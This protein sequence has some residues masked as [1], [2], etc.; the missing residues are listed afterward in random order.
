MKTT[1]KIKSFT[2]KSTIVQ[3]YW[4]DLLIFTYTVY[5][6]YRGGNIELFLREN[7]VTRQPDFDNL[8][9]FH[10]RTFILESY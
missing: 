3:E 8:S 1:F 7:Y 4:D 2:N 5:D 10:R 9:E 6:V